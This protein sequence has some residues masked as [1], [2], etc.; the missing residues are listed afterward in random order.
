MTKC[1]QCNS[2]IEIELL[3]EFNND[4]YCD[5][6]KFEINTECSHCLGDL[7]VD[8]SE[9]DSLICELCEADDAKNEIKNIN[10]INSNII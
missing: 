2:E 4:Y 10:W 1:N 6:C 9:S 7:V 5:D 3:T 8:L